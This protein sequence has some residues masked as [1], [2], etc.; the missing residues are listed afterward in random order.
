MSISTMQRDI[1]V[2]TLDNG[3]HVITEP[4]PSVRSV[5]VGVWV[6]TG[7]RV[8][9][10][11][12]NGISHFIEHMLFKGSDRRSAEEIAQEVD[13]IGGMLDAFTSRD[14]VGFNTK[15]LDEH[16]D[17]AFDILADLVL[18]PRFA[19]DDLEKEKGVVLEELKMEEDNP[20]SV[21]HDLF[22]ANFWRKHPLGRP[23]IGT[24]K[25]ITGFTSEGL[26][27][28][29]DQFY[30]P[31]NLTITAAGSLKHDELV[32][33]ADR[34]F[35]R[36]KAGGDPV[37]ISSPTP[38]PG[39][40][41]KNKKS[42]QQVQFCLGMPCLP[43]THPMR[44]AAYLLNLVLGGSMSSRLFQNIR[45]RQG[46]AYS[47]GS[48]LHLYHETGCMAVYAGASPSNV[49]ALLDGTLAE[50]R[51]IKEEPIPD[52]ELQ[53]AKSHMKGSLMLSLESTSSRM[54][55]L[56]RQWLNFQRFFTLDE[57]LDQIESVTAQQIQSMAQEFFASD[58]LALTLLGR[59]DDLQI[60][61]DR[62]AC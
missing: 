57:L 24:R 37:R 4:M 35:G 10:A 47:I 56:S 26:R 39:V 17:L 27:R 44:F 54:T 40:F 45:E 16:L 9:S 59:L 60:D 2:S 6:D 28:H 29:H 50:L 58:Q 38:Q 30:T 25:T 61:R 52:D 18:H 19:E 42:L 13:S 33:L 32:R 5:A 15:V 11:A 53:R 49:P 22:I 48:E 7:S 20:E 51:R 23:I 8:E 62:L 1:A 36:L 3:I 55:N 31:V 46:L 41:L 14:Q 43:S 12:D 34:Y 21:V